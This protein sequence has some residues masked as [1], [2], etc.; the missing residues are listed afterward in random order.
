MK[1]L[2]RSI[3]ALFLTI[4]TAACGSSITGPYTP[5]SGSYTPDSGSYTPDSG[6]YTPDSGS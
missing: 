1:M 4:A 6:S 3:L 5:D 2:R